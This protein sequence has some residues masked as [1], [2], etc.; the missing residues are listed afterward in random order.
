MHIENFKIFSDLVDGQSFSRAG[1]LNGITQSA[2]SQQLRALESHFNVLLLDRSQKQ[3]RLTPEGE[4]LHE[5]AKDIIHRYN[6]LVGDLQD[7]KKVISGTIRISTIHSIGLHV[8]PPF[9][10]QFLIAYPNVNVRVE[11]RRSNMAVE[12]VLRN[13]VDLGLIAYPAKVRNLEVISFGEDKMVIICN[14]QHAFA[15]RHE[16]SAAELSGQRFIGFDHDIPTRKATDQVFRELHAE[17]S[18]RMEFDNI[19]M[20]KRAVEAGAGLAFV[21]AAAVALEVAQGALIKLD[22]KDRHISRP[23]AIV[24]RKGCVLTPAMKKFIQLVTEEQQPAIGAVAT[25]GAVAAAPAKK[26]KAESASKK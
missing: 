16:V 5:S 23:L 1:K 7:M 2:V 11:Y 13:E 19:E 4:K 15:S 9:V 10:R 3:F 8:L 21:P 20:L 24:Y 18:P 26:E 25:T 6:V 12:D 17:L 14:P 22:L